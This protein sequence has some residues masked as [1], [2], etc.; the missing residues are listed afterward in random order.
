MS[1]CPKIVDKKSR[2][3]GQGQQGSRLDGDMECNKV[4]KVII[5]C[6]YSLGLFSVWGWGGT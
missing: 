2:V 5:R 3:G 4:I 6:M 1:V